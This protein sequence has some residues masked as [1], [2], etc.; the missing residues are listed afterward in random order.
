M[1]ENLILQ[2]IY[3]PQQELIVGCKYLYK[4]YGVWQ[5]GV[6]CTPFD[7]FTKG[8]KNISYA[9]LKATDKYVTDIY[10]LPF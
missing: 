9:S 2:K 8:L 10:K 6:C 7:K 4:A 3:N 1:D 5:V